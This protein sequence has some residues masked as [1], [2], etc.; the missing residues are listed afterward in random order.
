MPLLFPERAPHLTERMDDPTCDLGT[1]HATYRRFG[2][3][4]RL[5]SGWGWLYRRHM[6]PRMV[7]ENLYRVL[8]VGFGGGDIPLKLGRWAAR[9]G[10]ALHITAIDPDPRA[11]EYAR[12]LHVPPNVCFQRAHTR[13][14][15]AQGARFDFVISNHLLHHLSDRE[16]QALCDDTARLGRWVLHNDVERADV[17]YLGFAAMGPFFRGSYIT[18]DGLTSVRR[19]YTAEE[20]SA[21]APAG[22]SVARS[23]PYRLLLSHGLRP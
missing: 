23:Y 6:R 2:A 12:T 20:L 5:F 15:A 11:L 7:P 10:L 18:L 13:D 21:L 19:A 3:V 17:A 14:L 1:L 22:W 16:L 9:D 8:D 4:N